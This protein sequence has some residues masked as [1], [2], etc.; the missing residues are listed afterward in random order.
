[1]LSIYSTYCGI[2]NGHL[3]VVKYIIENYID[4]SL[5]YLGYP[6]GVAAKKGYLDIVKYLIENGADISDNSLEM[7]YRKADTELIKYLIENGANLDATISGVYRTGPIIAYSG[8]KLFFTTFL[9]FSGLIHL[10]HTL[11]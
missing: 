1:M 9:I 8:E 11:A 6:L 4:S 3:N 7:I 10:V 5:S 2:E